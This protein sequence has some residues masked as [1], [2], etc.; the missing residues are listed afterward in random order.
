MELARHRRGAVLRLRMAIRPRGG[1]GRGPRCRL[2]PRGDGSPRCLPG[3]G[4]L[5]RRWWRLALGA[6]GCLRT[7]RAGGP[8]RLV[9]LPRRHLRHRG[10]IAP[11][12]A[13]RLGEVEQKAPG[14]CAAKLSLAPPVEIAAAR[15]LAVKQNL[16][17]AIH[18]PDDKPLRSKLRAALLAGAG[19]GD[20]VAEAKAAPL[21]LREGVP[22]A[23]RRQQQRA[24]P[25]DH[26]PRLGQ[27]RRRPGD[28]PL[29]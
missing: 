19:I 16:H 29:D 5:S 12:S 11:G 21:E 8:P 1:S 3:D 7:V 18:D 9:G 25:T 27:P 24:G 14:E 4:L 17:C 15:K 20:A 26:L 22:L 6:A 28:S 13:H 23:D 10:C 2:R